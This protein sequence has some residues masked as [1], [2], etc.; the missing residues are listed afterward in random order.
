M[1]RFIT[2]YENQLAHEERKRLL[3]EG[4]NKMPDLTRED[5]LGLVRAVWCRLDHAEAARKGYLQ[6]GPTLP[7]S[8]PVPHDGVFKDLRNVLEAIAKDEDRQVAPVHGRGAAQTISS[9]D[10]EGRGPAASSHL[11]RRVTVDA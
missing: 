9:Q 8:G 1:Q 10:I 3:L 2:Q 6:T 11:S 4:S 7:M 5:I